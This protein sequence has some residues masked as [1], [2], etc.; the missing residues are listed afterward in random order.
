MQ[1]IFVKILGQLFSKKAGL[2]YLNMVDGE[3]PDFSNGI[4][5]DAMPN[6][7]IL[8][9]YEIWLMEGLS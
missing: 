3:R 6:K 2:Y 5:K 1:I 7:G 4:A 9:K 8:L